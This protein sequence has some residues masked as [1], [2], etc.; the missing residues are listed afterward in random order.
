MLSSGIRSAKSL[1]KG[2]CGIRDGREGDWGW[3]G[4]GEGGVKEK[5]FFLMCVLEAEKKTLHNC[6]EFFI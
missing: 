3:G 2:G 4:E 5:S 1:G 6:R